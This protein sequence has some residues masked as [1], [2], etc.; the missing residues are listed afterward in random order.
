MPSATAKKKIRYRKED[1]PPNP[2]KTA[3]IPKIKL[4]V[5]RSYFLVTQRTIPNK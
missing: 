2:K 1:N 3:D 5:N 4:M